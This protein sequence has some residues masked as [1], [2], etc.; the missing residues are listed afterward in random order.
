M[1]SN[2]TIE[3]VEDIPTPIQNNPDE[4]HVEVPHAEEPHAEEPPAQEPHAQK[5]QEQKIV[6]VKPKSTTD[7]VLN[8]VKKIKKS[9]IG[10]AAIYACFKYNKGFNVAHFA[11]S[12]VCPTIYLTYVVAVDRH[13]LFN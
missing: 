10:V 8:N 9:I 7:I 5:P 13:C 4:P 1:M 3:E 2:H 12:I 11:T 6:V